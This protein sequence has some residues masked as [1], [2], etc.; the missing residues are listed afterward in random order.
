EKR[1]INA[2]VMRIAVKVGNGLAERNQF[3]AKSEEEL[4]ETIRLAVGFREGVGIANRASGAIRG[5]EARISLR[6]EHD[7]R[8]AALLGF[9]EGLLQ[10][11]NVGGVAGGK[12]DRIWKHVAQ[13]VAG[14]LNVQRRVG[15]A[16]ERP[17]AI[18][19]AGNRASDTEAE[20]II[21]RG[22]KP[23]RR[24]Y[25]GTAKMVLRK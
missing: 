21:R 25:G 2:E 15:D 11:N 8:G 22:V 12:F 3:R 10:P 7:G 19:D 17:A 1:L 5:V 4:D 23:P 9:S 14:A 16:T 18:F 20:W 6:D 13:I 24:L